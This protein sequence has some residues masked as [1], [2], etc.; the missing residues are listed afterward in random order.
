[1]CAFAPH[2]TYITFDSKMAKHDNLL[3][4]AS[5][6]TCYMLGRDKDKIGLKETVPKKMLLPREPNDHDFMELSIIV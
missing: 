2:Y 4:F 5:T 6:S 3:E 1:M